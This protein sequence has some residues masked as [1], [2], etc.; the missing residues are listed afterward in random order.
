[1]LSWIM[2]KKIYNILI[3][4]KDHN[5]RLIY[6]TTTTL[7]TCA[8]TT[9]WIV[10]LYYHLCCALSVVI[11]HTYFDCKTPTDIVPKR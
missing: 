8:P 10:Y 5:L 11:K 1:M 6:I 4:I 2:L 7:F 3:E 9:L